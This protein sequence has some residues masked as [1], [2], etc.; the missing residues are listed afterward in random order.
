MMGRLAG[1]G[2]AAAAA[3]ARELL[4]ALR[5]HRRRATAAS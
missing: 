1:L 2:R 4:D 3:R 5:P